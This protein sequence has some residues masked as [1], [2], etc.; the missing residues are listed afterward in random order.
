MSAPRIGKRRIVDERIAGV[1][2]V[3]FVAALLCVVIVIAG[4]N[5]GRKPGTARLEGSV[6][7][8]GQP[9]PAEAKGSISFRPTG[10]GQPTS[11]QIVD[12]KYKCDDVPLGEVVVF[13]QLVLPTGKMVSDGGRSYPELRNL[14]SS[15]Y[16]Q[17]I[18]LNV[19][20]DNSNQD[21]ELA[22]SAKP[23]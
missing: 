19:T 11:A 3:I 20:D 22:G 10:K 7:I 4:C 14:V 17:G 8:D 13:V 1:R 9:P 23:Q 18:Q 16:D 2:E 15:K 6:T 21:F 5:G 12:G